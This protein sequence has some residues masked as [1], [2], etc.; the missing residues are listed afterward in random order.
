VSVLR[1]RR[2]AA[3][4]GAALAL[5][6]LCSSASL[7]ARRTTAPS[8]NVTVYFVITDK[9]IAYE[10]LRATTGGS[11]DL[12]LEKYVLRGDFAN[13]IVINRGKKPHS[14]DFLG[15]KLSLSPGRR[16]HFFRSLVVRGK[17]PYRSTTDPGK[18]FRG[19]FPVY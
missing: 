14:F 10:I 18:A 15:K 12:T 2:V 1:A 13:F 8:Q 3:V 7:A 5:A 4:A 19:V 6:L 11:G 17:F 9:K 16:A